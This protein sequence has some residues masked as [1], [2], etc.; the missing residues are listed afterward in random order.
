MKLWGG[1]ECSRVRVG[2][3]TFDQLS[4]SGHYDRPDD[5]DRIAELG[6]RTVRYPVLWEKAATAVPGEYD[7]Q[8]ADERLPR[9][10]ERGIT[11]IAG[12]VH[13]GCGPEYTHLADSHFAEGLA[14]YA[15][16]LARRFPWLSWYT[17]VNEPLTTARFSGLYGVWQPHGRS[18]RAFVRML[19]NECKAIVLAMRAIREVIPD[20]RLVQTEDLGTIYST[21]HL[22]YQADFENERRWLTWDLL[23]GYVDVTHPLHEWLVESGLTTRELAWFVENRC[24]PQIIGI[25]HY[26]TSDRF[27]DHDLARHAARCHGGNGRERYADVEA[28]RMLERPGT[29][30]RNILLAAAQRYHL[31]LA[32]TEVHIGCTED[33]QVRWLHEAWTICEQLA[34]SGVD[35]RAVTSWALLGSYD[36]DTLMTAGGDTYESGAWCLRDGAPRPTAVA[37]HIRKLTGIDGSK[38]VS[39]LDTPG[40]WRRPE[41][42]LFDAMPALPGDAHVITGS[43]ESYVRPPRHRL[44]S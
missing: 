3:R 21:P 40:W 22:Q 11:P 18:N 4:R 25:D 32:L 39:F 28:V 42:L 33:E 24:P 12:L 44:G 2:T 38:V 41:R 43:R 30:L 13:H 5:L 8:F 34:A 1:I 37:E 27:L 29:S 10:R 31:P 26:I 6:I 20:A 9:L 19:F 16:Q 7:F 17:P 14:D 35:V 15:G 23:C 36:W